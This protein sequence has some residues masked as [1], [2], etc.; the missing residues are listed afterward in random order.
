MANAVVTTI[1]RQKM[2]Q[3]RAGDITLPKI[4]GMAF[5]DGGVTSGGVVIEPTVNQESLNNELL[6]KA[7]SGH[8][9]PSTTVCRYTCKLEASELPGENISELALYDEDG[10]FVAIKNFTSKGKDSDLEMTFSVDDLF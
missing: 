2:L 8:T 5:G 10:D 4:V 1:A 6:R 9:F 7:V 3:A